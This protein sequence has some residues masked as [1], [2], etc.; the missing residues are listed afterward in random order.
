LIPQKTVDLAAGEKALTRYERSDYCPVP[1]A[2]PILE[3]MVA[4]VLADAMIENW[5]VIPWLKYCLGSK[6]LSKHG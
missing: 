2:V 4:L 1:R 6:L 5:A 3:A